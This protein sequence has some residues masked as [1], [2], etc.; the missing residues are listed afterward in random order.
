MSRP[1]A[2]ILAAGVGRRLAALTA[3]RPKALVEVGGLSLLE[4]ALR[5]LEAAGFEDALVVTGHHADRIDAFAA[6][7]GG[8]IRISC[9]RNAEYDR[10]NN[11][12]SFLYAEDA[13]G[14]GFCLLNSDIVFDGSILSDV[15]AANDGSWLVIDADEPLGEEEMKVKLR[16]NGLVERVSKKLPPADCAGEYIGIARFDAHGAAAVVAAARALVAD[17]RTDLYYEDAIDS[18]AAALPIRTIPT[19]ARKWTEIDDMAD[20]NRALA[21]AAELDAGGR[22]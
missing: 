19:R 21:V 12:V 20:Y 2:V 9:R 7:F 13:L 22:S 18:A 15:T 14:D 5:A 11:I 8:R 16:A 1:L 6:E 3:D 17:G 10:A 4:R